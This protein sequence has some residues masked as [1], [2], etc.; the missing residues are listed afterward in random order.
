MF[1]HG[2][3]PASVVALH[4]FLLEVFNHPCELAQARTAIAVDARELLARDDD[5]ET[6]FH[7]D[8]HTEQDH[9]RKGNDVV[10][11]FIFMAIA[12][13]RSQRRVGRGP[14]NQRAQ[15]VDGLG[16]VYGLLPPVIW[17]S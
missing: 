1:R 8:H 10:Q 13:G 11:Y 6:V 16:G 4:A 2:S 7:R 12:D 17:T 14:D 9:R 3:Q 15:L 5:A